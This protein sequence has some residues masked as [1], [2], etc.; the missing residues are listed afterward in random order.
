[1]LCIIMH[2]DVIMP[3]YNFIE[4]SK[5]YSRKSA[6]LWNYYENIPADPITNSESFIY[7]T[8]IT[9]KTVNNENTK[10]VEFSVPL[11]HLSSFWRTLDM[12]LI[13]C[14][15]SMTLTWSKNCV[16]TE[17]TTKDADPNAEFPV[18]ETTAP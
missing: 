18:L 2:Y 3:M 17:E 12:P 8:S 10:E 6:D 1:M 16:I 13:N 4:S 11:M 5:K 14:E 7:K 15:I 9:G